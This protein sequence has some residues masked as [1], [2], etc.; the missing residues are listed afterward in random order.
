MPS[1][2]LHFPFISCVTDTEFR[3]A[4]PSL[5]PMATRLR[6]D[7]TVGG[8]A[9]WATGLE[10]SSEGALGRW[11]LPTAARVDLLVCRSDHRPG[12]ASPA[13]PFGSLTLLSPWG[14]WPH[15]QEEEPTGRPAPPPG[16]GG[17]RS[18]GRSG[19]PVC[20]LT[21][22]FLLSCLLLR[23]LTFQYWGFVFFHKLSFVSFSF[24]GTL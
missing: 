20:P 1:L 22:S 2:I 16:S 12:L 13:A 7:M 21:H 15:S 4:S 24:V 5:L 9:P 18:S 10:C 23:S 3:M 14:L 8:P 19:N 11:A 17:Q 6:G